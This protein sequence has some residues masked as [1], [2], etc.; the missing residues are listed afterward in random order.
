MADR[1]RKRVVFGVCGG[2]AAYKAAAAVSRLVQEGL[3]VH[4]VMTRA[5][6]AFVTPLTFEVLSG[7][8][9]HTDLFTSQRLGRV[10]HVTLARTADLC[11]VAPAT[12]N[13][14]GKL[15]AGI[16]DDF[17]TTV[18]VGSAAPVLLFP[19]MEEHMYRSE[20]VQANLARLR[21]RGVRVVE[22]ETGRLASGAEG[23]GRLPE[24]DAIVDRVLAELRR[25]RDLE[26]LHVLV[27][28][29]P[30]R[31][32]L[33]PVRFLS[34]PSTGRMGFAVAAAARDRGARVTLV[35]GPTEVAPPEGVTR[36]VV[37]TAE[38]MMEAV[39]SRFE[40]ADVVIKTAAV[41]DYRPAERSPRKIKKSDAPLTVTLVRNP[42]ILAALGQRKGRRILVGFAA[43]TDEPVEHALRKLREKGLDLIVVNDVTEPGAGFAV[44]TNRVLIIDARGRVEELPLLSKREVADRLLDAVRELLP[45]RGT[46]A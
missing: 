33:D 12:A 21:A 23:L 8:P 19:A 9:V 40:A 35:T 41:S 11:V 10:D 36:V 28:A 25:R 4:V 6:T 29:G 26:G 17:L 16:A 18:L 27:T 3:D 42:D 13:L 45:A 1:E 39:L 30:T 34:N 43:E 37:E 31:E 44:E 2:I 24:P 15:A 46:P 7:N 5:A 22:P 38:E 20:A 14:V 32:P